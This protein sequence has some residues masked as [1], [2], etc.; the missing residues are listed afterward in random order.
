VS[1][2]AESARERPTIWRSLLAL[3][4]LVVLY[5]PIR[6]YT[7][8]ASLPINLE[9]YRVVVLVVLLLWLAALLVDPRIRLRR[10]G[11]D[12]PIVFFLV[13]ILLSLIANVHRVSDVGG[14][15]IKVVSFFLSYVLVFY[16]VVSVTRRRSEIDFLVAVLAGGG[17]ILA[18]GAIV[19]A[20]TG[21]NVFDHLRAGLPFLRFH[22]GALSSADVFR[23][24]GR[25][26]YASAQ[27]PIALGGALCLLLPL[28]LYRAYGCGRRSWWAA[29][30]LITLGVLAARSRTPILMLGAEFVVFLVLRVREMARLWPALVPTII[31]GY[32]LVPGTVGAIKDSFLP[33]GGLVAQQ[34]HA[35]VGSGRVAT[36]GPALEHEFK[37]HPIVGEGFGTRITQPDALVPVPNAP[38]LDDQWLGVLLETGVIGAFGL[39][40][41]FVRTF[42][43]F[44]GV[45]QRDPSSRGWLAAAVTASSAAYAVGM[46]FYDSFS[47][48]QVTFLLLIVL[49]LGASTALADESEWPAQR[50]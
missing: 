7:L 38:I 27:H 32:L 30:G 49:G 14:D 48:V 29:V 2:I 12:A 20:G 36:L 26:A 18:I 5:I 34:A 10:S 46:F 15:V 40:W 41:L 3:I 8:P 50:R 24:G 25:R 31:A 37:P 1:F 16:L 6:R 33:K 42:R 9:I 22:G 17:A 45:A 4:V 21:F 47:F 35:N 19:Q 28:A 43:R 11:L 23:G 39:V 44:G 13:A